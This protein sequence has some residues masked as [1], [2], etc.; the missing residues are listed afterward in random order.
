MSERPKFKRV[1]KTSQRNYRKSIDFKDAKELSKQKQGKEVVRV[2]GTAN[3]I[4]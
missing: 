1:K 2:E 4:D 3:S